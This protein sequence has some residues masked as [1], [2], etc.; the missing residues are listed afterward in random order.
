MTKNQILIQKRLV[1]L[2]DASQNNLKE[3]MSLQRQLMTYG[4]ML[5]QK[6]FDNIV[7]ADIADIIDLY[8]DSINW[9]KEM[10]GGKY[11]FKSLYGNFPNDVMSMSSYELWYSQIL[12]YWTACHFKSV[13]LPKDEAFEYTEYKMIEWCTEDQ[14]LDIFTKL[15]SVGNSLTPQDTETIKW[16]VSSGYELRYP[17]QIPFKENLAVIVSLCPGFT[18]STVTD[19]LRV[20][21]AFSGGDPSI[22]AIPKKLKKKGKNYG[23][24]IKERDKH[25]FKLNTDQKIKLLYLLENSNRDIRDM[26]QGS[27][28]GRWIRLF[29][30]I[31][32][33]RYKTQYPLSFQLADHLRNQKRKGKPS[34]QP[35]IRTWYSDVQQAFKKSTLTGLLKLSERPGEL[36]RQIDYL[37]RTYPKHLNDIFQYLALK[38]SQVSNKVLYETFVH[39]QGRDEKIARSIFIKGA[40]K[41]TE[42]PTLKPL[43]NDVIEAVSESIWRILSDKYA[44]LEPLGNCYIDEKLKMIP[45]PTNMRSM[46]ES[47]VPTIRGQRTPIQSTKSTLRPFV[48][49]YDTSG[50]E[51]IDLHGFMLGNT[52]QQFG[53]NG[54]ART[55]YGCFSG[56][57]RHRQGPCAEYVDI[58]ISKA[59][60]AGFKYFVMVL[61][62]Y[63]Q[64]PFSSLKD[65]YTGCMEVDNPSANKSWIPS[66]VTNAMKLNSSSQYCLVGVYD[67]EKRE[68]IH[69]DLDWDTFRTVG[70]SDGN[71][72]LKAIEPYCKDPKFSVYDLVRLHVEARGTITPP[73]LADKHFLYEDFAYSYEKTLE[74]LG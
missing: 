15:L 73:E 29:E 12:H 39:F 41:K 40:R 27:K 10:T 57:V 44:T 3:V 23:E 11:S 64:R 31:G 7:K 35:V 47:L 32:M 49:W 4:F 17:K 50:R 22:P 30:V 6:A 16:F 9:L 62:N 67:L 59:I 25:K 51:D 72:L 45:L 33:G 28:Y 70:S 18:V 55:N 74:L 14:F 65:C 66:N 54:S 48:H 5:T 58:N 21:Y 2:K 37:V 24:N 63:Q 46:S 26:K 42:L 34:G 13:G 56:D 52:T 20:A 60:E 53:F 19:V 36:L 8:K 68:Y 38:G 71:K 1:N 69:L 61:H 43:S